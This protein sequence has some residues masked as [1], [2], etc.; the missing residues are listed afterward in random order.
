MIQLNLTNM[1]MNLFIEI[2]KIAE[3]NKSLLDNLIAEMDAGLYCVDESGNIIFINKKLATLLEY[4]IPEL[5]QLNFYD[6]VHISDIESINRD[7]FND[8][9]TADKIFSNILKLN[10]RSGKIKVAKTSSTR[11]IIDNK[12][13]I[14]GFAF[15][16]TEQTNLSLELER[17]EQALKHESSFLNALLGSAPEA[18]VI[19]DKNNIIKQSNPAFEKIF[20]YSEDEIIGENLNKLL[21]HGER[22][23]EAEDITAQIRKGI[24]VNLES[25]RYRKDGTKIYVD[26]LGAPV[27]MNTT[28]VAIY[29]IYRDVSTNIQYRERLEKNQK[30]LSL[31]IN[32]IPGVI[33]KCA[34]DDHW[35]MEYLSAKCQNLTGYH[36]SSLINN[37]ARSFASIIVEDDKT[38]LRKSIE[39]AITKD[40]Q[41][42]FN[43]RIEQPDGKQIWVN[44]VG[45]A[46][47]NKNGEVEYLEGFISDHSKLQKAFQLRKA[48]FDISDATIQSNNPQE[49]Y[50][51]IHMVLN[52][53]IYTKNLFIALYLKETD[54]VQ[55]VYIADEKCGFDEY[56]VGK[57]LTGYMIHNGKSLLINQAEIIQIHRQGDIDLIGKICESWLGVPLKIGNDTIGAIVVQSY[58][59]NIHYSNEDKQLL[60]F[61]S[62][63]L[64]IAIQRINYENDLR[65]AKEKAEEAD[66]LKSSFLANMSHEIRSPMNAILGFSELLK[67]TDIES[68][69][70]Q[71]Y[72]S[73]VIKRSKDLMALIDEIID[74]SKIDAG[75]LKLKNNDILV[76]ELL[77]ELRAFYELEKIKRN[78]NNLDIRLN[79]PDNS[80]DIILHVDIPRF[81]QII[82]NL[83][84][85][86]IKFTSEGYIEI[87][88][89]LQNRHILFYVKDTG[90]GIPTNKQ[91]LIFDRFR[92]VDESHTREYQG[93]GLG[94]S[95]A[96]AIVEK[97]KGQIWV[98]SQP[99][100]GSTFFF[101][102]PLI[103]SQN[104]HL[105]EWQ[106]NKPYTYIQTA[107]KTKYGSKVL[108][109]EDDM[110]NFYFLETLLKIRDLDCT[111]ASDGE[112]AIEIVKEE[113]ISLILMDIRMPNMDGL[114]AT[115]RLRKMGYNMPI[116]AQTA[117]AMSDDKQISLDA[118]CSDYLPKPI[119]KEHLY[120]LLDKYL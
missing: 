112:R 47:K 20:G 81:N 31:L 36:E 12:T 103:E 78:K 6:V 85:N 16:I 27:Y 60:E 114:E 5:M 17:K 96:K 33:Y 87:G 120:S 4:E 10:T 66:N 84:I 49:L 30:E 26:I 32:N 29:G 76:N 77:Q 119:K 89:Q 53:V 34:N 107:K 19:T 117:N 75:I 105:K 109:V 116:I 111:H 38:Q 73:I 68:V 92:Q 11:A 56:P 97:M 51:N 45:H 24:T 99:G 95:I 14:F 91:S 64:A 61:V 28:L 35:T 88:Y 44:E 54:S 43:Y 90:I 72:I 110:T 1:I 67:D 82:N 86:A 52:N 42:E 104:R 9:H 8:G 3:A 21:A 62:E 48:L 94:L 18:I 23:S 7:K 74:L 108:V 71:E 37:S 58:Q 69:Q 70:A 63:H 118:G 113:D 115:R 106:H 2:L 41:W 93:S 100:N 98:K 50:K 57:S 65:I 13:V 15:D 25:V 80:K 46:V 83:V 39:D 55:L 102:I 101:T 79:I 22:F 40:A 59:K